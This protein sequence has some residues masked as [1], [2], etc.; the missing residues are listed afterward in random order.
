[1]D[2]IGHDGERVELIAI[3]FWLTVAKGVQHT[4]GDFGNAKI[5]RAGAR[6]VEKAVHSEEGYAGGEALSWEDAVRWEGSIQAADGRSSPS[7]EDGVRG[8]AYIGSGWS[9]IKFSG[10]FCAI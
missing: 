5:L 8:G 3:Q 9:W 4:S 7:E 10:F 2:V 1:M 6:V